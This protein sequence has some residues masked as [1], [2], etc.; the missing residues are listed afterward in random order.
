MKPTLLAMPRAWLLALGARATHYFLALALL[1]IWLAPLQ[2]LAPPLLMRLGLT[3]LLL[4]LLA[5]A[6]LSRRARRAQR[7]L[8]AL[9][10]LSQPPA[11]LAAPIEEDRF[12]AL[13]EQ[14]LTGIYIIQ[15]Q[16]LVYANQAM[17]EIFGYASP[18]ELIHQPAM[19]RVAAEDHERVRLA[20]RRRGQDN[21][22]RYRFHG[23]R[24]DGSR[25]VVEVHGRNIMHEGRP[26]LTGTLIDETESHSYHEEMA[27]LVAQKTLA[28]Y[29]SEQ[30]L[31]TILDNLPAMVSYYDP[32]LR[33]RFGNQAYC[34]WHRVNAEQLLGQ[35][36]PDLIGARQYAKAQQPIEEALRGSAQRFELELQRPGGDSWQGQIHL[37]PDLRAGVLSGLFCLIMDISPL[38]QAVQALGESE[39]R[40]RQLFEAAPVG[41]ALF[42]GDGQCIMAN[43]AQAD[44][45]GGSRAELLEQ[46]FRQMPTWQRTGLRH[47]AEK[48]LE[49]GQPQHY[50]LK[51]ETNFGKPIEIECQFT[52]ITLQS[53]PYLM[54]LAKDIAPFRQAAL[55]M[56]QAMDAEWE[57]NLLDQQ[58]RQ[59]V[60]NITD[61][62]FTIDLDGCLLDANEVYVRQSG[63]S[64]EQ[65]LSL[66]IFDL[67]TQESAPEVMLRMEQI[68]QRGSERFEAWHQHRDGSLWPCDISASFAPV[69]GKIYA[70]VRDITVM[71]QAENQIRRLA[72]FDSLTQLPNRQHLLDRLQQALEASRTSQHYGALLFIDLDNFKL[73]NDTLGHDMGDRLL[74][75]VAQRLMACTRGQDTVA[76]LGGD[77]FIILVE[78]LDPE[79][80]L[81]EQTIRH[82]A[83]T[84]ISA[85]NQPYPFEH[86]EFHNT[87]SIGVA[88]FNH[89][90]TSVEEMLKHA[91]LAMYQAKASGRNTLCF[92]DPDSQTR[93][94]AKSALDT[95]LRLALRLNQLTLQFQPQV[96][97]QGLIVGAEALVRWNHPKQGILNP[98]EFIGLV[99]DSELVHPLGLKILEM[100]CAQLQA[101][102]TDAQLSE[103][104]VSVNVS[105][106][107]FRHHA[108][109]ENIRAQLMDSGIRPECLK[110]EL[111]ESLL[112]HDITESAA[113]MAQIK[114]MGVVFSLDD[115]GTGYSSLGYLRSLPLEQL[116]IDQS[117]VRNILS[118]SN[119]A[120]IVRAIIVMGH[121]LGLSIVA[122]GVDNAAQWALLLREGCD[123]GQGHFFG[124]ALPPTDFERLQRHNAEDISRQP[125]EPWV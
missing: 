64:R 124:P 10:A 100:A 119:D 118:D 50:E 29:Q 121:S 11:T 49:D 87:P 65:L 33:H 23:L 97:R 120:A 112:L 99:E 111:T 25:I 59:V 5:V 85:L 27:Q 54:L 28:L 84:V 4:A 79:R 43:Q 40:F 13:V 69:E 110:L 88:L 14:S 96:D 26:A 104:T 16:Q 109:V 35:R 117:F 105:A 34:D 82:L 12:R 71:K 38:K 77:E 102:S 114:A 6:R 47:I 73:L 8:A 91:D 44:L 83:N 22:T 92:F 78:G 106:R 21:P 30:E 1:T 48:T 86:Q 17:A 15:D 115:F 52:L 75:I 39:F 70:F 24:R 57:K 67:E 31:H 95:E 41:M 9:E 7:R 108:F 125:C 3:A 123:H 62:F 90:A 61:G 18:Q 68:Q 36:L 80:E 55:L 72:F 81:A 46:N 45:M 53:E 56:K 58:Y 51:M 93:V 2:H 32:E 122:E 60:E 66:S 101:W 116:K 103:L 89:Q 113:R 98:S 76:R 63:Y 107:Q 19:D 20:I 42:R 37:I 74:V 94:E